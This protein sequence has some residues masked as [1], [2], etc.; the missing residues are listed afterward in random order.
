MTSA[1][2]A[3]IYIHLFHVEW[4]HVHPE[5]WR[6]RNLCDSFWRFYGHESDGAFY[7]FEG[8]EHA[9]EAGQLYLIPAGVRFSTRSERE[10]QQFYIHFDVLGLPDVMM[11]ELFG[12]PLKLPPSRELQ[13]AARNVSRTRE[14]AQNSDLLLHLQIKSFLYQALCK[15][16]QSVPASQVALCQE[17]SGALETVRPALRYIEENLGAT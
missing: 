7:E 8:C 9:L 10:L 6:L 4:F 12:A 5:Q 14:D 13:G 17:I 3:N 2:I 16:L 11:R 1:P 15:Y